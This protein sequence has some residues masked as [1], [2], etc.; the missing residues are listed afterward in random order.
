MTVEQY[1]VCI[2][3]VH[4]CDAGGGAARVIPAWA[5][6]SLLALINLKVISIFALNLP[7]P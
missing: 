7:N 3:R 6:L 5:P 2:W 1:K 4:V